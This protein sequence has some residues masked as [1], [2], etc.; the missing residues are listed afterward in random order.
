M[1]NLGVEVRATKNILAESS[2]ISRYENLHYSPMKIRFLG[3]SCL[4]F[5]ITLAGFAEPASES[6]PDVQHTSAPVSSDSNR[7]ISGG[8]TDKAKMG[9][10]KQ[11][12]KKELTPEEVADL[13]PFILFGAF[14]GLPPKAADEVKLFAGNQAFSEFVATEKLS[15]WP[16]ANFASSIK[17][18]HAAAFE[19]ALKKHAGELGADYVVIYSAEDDIANTFQ[20]RFDRL[21][22]CAKAFKRLPVKLGL[23]RDEKASH[24]KVYK[25]ADFMP[26]SKAAECGLRKGDILVKVGGVDVALEGLY[27]KKA[28]WWKPGDKVKVEVER[29]GKTVELE[30]E[31]VAG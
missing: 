29:E 7:D 23:V 22:F 10:V 15:A 27:A 6:S 14:A 1:L 3:L 4:L 20:P 30:V 26:G 12:V 24:E 2:R 5:S 11:L 13:K 31:L 28:V 8:K 17:P 9:V 21:V 19:I 18:P 16:I 25:I